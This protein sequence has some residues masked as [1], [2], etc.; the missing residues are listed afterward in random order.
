MKKLCMILPMALILC[1]M[2]GNLLI[3]AVFDK[4]LLTATDRRESVYII[5]SFHYF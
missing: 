1:F 2:A 4:K 5:C 3:F